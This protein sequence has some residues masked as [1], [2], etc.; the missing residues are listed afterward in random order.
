MPLKYATQLEN[1]NFDRA[2]HVNLGSS[3]TA[4]EPFPKQATTGKHVGLPTASCYVCL[5]DGPSEHDASLV[6]L[7]LKHR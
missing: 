2:G 5:H 4:G 3:W 1:V 7:M 6:D